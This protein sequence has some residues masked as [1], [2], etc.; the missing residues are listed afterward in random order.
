M[1]QLRVLTAIQQQTAMWC[2]SISEAWELVMETKTRLH[3]PRC[4]LPRKKEPKLTF[5]D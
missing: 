1:L 5:R 4:H 2:D 3:F